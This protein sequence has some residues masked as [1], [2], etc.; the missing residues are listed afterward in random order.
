M[1]DKEIQIKM[2]FDGDALPFACQTLGVERMRDHNYS[3]VFTIV[4]TILKLAGTGLY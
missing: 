2:L 3:D 4:S 1:I